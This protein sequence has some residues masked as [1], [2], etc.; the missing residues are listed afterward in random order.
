MRGISSTVLSLWLTFGLGT[1]IADTD[2]TGTAVETTATSNPK[3]VLVA[4][5]DDAIGPAS[6]SFLL[7]AIHRAEDEG[8]DCL[9]IQLDTPGG[10]DEAMRDIVK[11]ILAADV[12]VVVYVA[13]SGARAASAGVFIL[14]AAHVAAMA[15]GTNTG[16]AHPVSLGGGD[17]DETMLA[18]IENDAASFIRALA[19]KR[20]RN[21]EW[22]E[23]AVRESAS[24][25]DTEALELGV[26]DLVA[27]SLRELLE[28]I[29]GK[30]VETLAG[31]RVLATRHARVV[32]VEMQWRE[33]ALSVIANPNIAYLLL[34]LGTLG[35][36]MELWNPG[37]IFPGVL[38]SICLLLAFFALQ[39]LPVNS[40]GL[41][42]LLLGVI[43]LVLEIK[44]TSFGLLTI[45]GV[46]AL[47]LGAL[48]L[49]DS[50]GDVIRVSW[51]VIVPTVL[52]VT[53]FFLFVVGKGLQAQRRQPVTGR[54]GMIGLRGVADSR[55]APLG[56]VLVRG[57]YWEARA[58][59]PIEEGQE[60]QVITVE[61]S[62]LIVRAAP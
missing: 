37:A 3:F 5:L 8:A 22:A 26:I 10:L 49:F 52:V 50:K 1:G 41:L 7:K 16:A 20:G 57:E 61:G 31:V 43:L 44:V 40:A 53:L 34:M 23:K 25:A 28:K 30:R 2:T 21:A 9:V 12:P 29:D 19:Q 55:I 42:L 60:I 45:G 15:P 54:E 27:G 14:L 51:A 46:T 17:V 6:A 58:D 62:R 48:L 35:L 18:K 24:I 39:V 4:T 13:P 36:M 32:E 59:A 56:R 38:G 11:G 33:R 47:T